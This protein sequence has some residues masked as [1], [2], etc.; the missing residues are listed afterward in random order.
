QSLSHLLKIAY[1]GAIAAGATAE[2]VIAAMMVVRAFAGTSLS[3]RVLERMSDDS[4]R[5]W[6]RATV[7][8]LGAIYLAAGTV[9]LLR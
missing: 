5:R 1:F 3:A 2:P 7:M 8:S 6:T 4:F 9:L